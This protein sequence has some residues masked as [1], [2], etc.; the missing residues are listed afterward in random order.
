[1]A[2]ELP[3][4]N[5]SGQSQHLR[6]AVLGLFFGGIFLLAIGAGFYFFGKSDTSDEIQIISAGEEKTNGSEIMVHVDGAVVTPGVY[7]LPQDSRV[8]DAVLVAGGF[9][10]QADQSKVNLAAKVTDGQKI[11]VFSVGEQVTSDKGQV[12][13]QNSD[14]I[15]INT[16]SESELDKL[17]GVGPVTAQKIVASR[18][19]SVPEDLLTKKAVSARFMKKLRT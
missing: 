13:S 4:P 11:H 2:E 16:A 17:P 10:P 5:T 12:I 9:S 19:Y 14:L 18:P 7:K 1:M 8:N 15:N 3:I 6:L